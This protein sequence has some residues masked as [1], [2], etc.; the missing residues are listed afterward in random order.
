MKTHAAWI[1]LLVVSGLGLAISSEVKAAVTAEHKKQIAE[2]NKDIGKTT[3]LISKREFDEAAKLLDE[4]EKKLKQIAK[5]ADVKE[6]DKALAGPLKQIV[7][8]RE[9]LEKKKPGGNS[10]GGA[11]VFERDVAPILVA[12]CLNCHGANNPRANLRMDT[13]AGIVQG[14]DSGPIVSPGK[15]DESPLVQR[16]T[17]TGNVRMPRNAPALSG[18]DIKK[19]SDW[20]AGGAAFKGNNAT[21]LNQ[22]K[23]TA[24]TIAKADAVPIQINKP[25][26]K[27]TVSFKDDI[28]P[29]MVNLCVNCHSGN[30]P[31]SGFSLETFEKLMKGGKS[32]RVVLPGNTKDSR[33]WHLVGEQDPIKMPPAQALITRT[34]HSN[35]RKWIEE[36]AKFD[37]PDAKA[38]IRSL[39]LTDAEKRAK[40]M[41]ALSND[42]LAKRRKERAEGLWAAALASDTPAIIEN[43]SFLVMGNAGEPRIKQVAEWAGT[44]AER[45]R[46]LFKIKEP[47]IWRGKLT[48]FVFKDRFSY[49]EFTQTNENVEIPADTKG[50]SRVSSTGDEAYVC[51]LDIGDSVTEDSP[52]VK[53]LVMGLLSEGLLQ[54]SSNRVPD[55]AAKGTG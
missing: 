36:G 11:G 28:A 49:A 12:R 41:A 9:Q 26:G 22:L 27:E 38:P 25:T 10:G 3:G 34:N 2:I 6:T 14:G 19:I 23:G 7:S 54:R 52:G 15:P 18:D 51:L 46:K 21:P 16:I 8:K 45:L 17:A 44:S 1:S 24:E 50:H 42:E 48:I 31:R 43:D 37:G 32:G 33:L 39:V 4:A 30:D 20:V 55:W 35:L 13:F 53:T 47:A 40:E 29:F 5:D